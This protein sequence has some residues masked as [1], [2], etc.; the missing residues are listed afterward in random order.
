MQPAPAVTVLPFL[1]KRKEAYLESHH[2]TW[3]AEDSGD[4]IGNTVAMP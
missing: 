2:I 3:L 4:T 1:N